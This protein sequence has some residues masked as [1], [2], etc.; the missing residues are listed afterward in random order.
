MIE[1]LLIISIPVAIAF[2]FTRNLD[3]S[4]DGPGERPGAKFFGLLFLSCIEEVF[5]WARKNIGKSV[6]IIVVVAGYAYAKSLWGLPVLGVGILAGC[7]FLTYLYKKRKAEYLKE[8]A[9]IKAAWAAEKATK[10]ENDSN[11]I[12]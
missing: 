8:D 4:G 7:A 1:I 10:H 6:L 9:A 5:I 12:R 3:L 11:N 2:Y